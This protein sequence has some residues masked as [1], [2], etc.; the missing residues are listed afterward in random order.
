MRIRLNPDHTEQIVCSRCGKEFTSRGIQDFAFAYIR[1][2]VPV[3]V[4]K[5]GV[6]CAECK[7]NEIRESAADNFIGGPLDKENK[8][9]D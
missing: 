5:P 7:E 9:A 8:D 6:L 1:N 3:Y 2:G 4:A